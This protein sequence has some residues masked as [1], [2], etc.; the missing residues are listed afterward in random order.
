MKLLS[1]ISHTLTEKQIEE[2][3]NRLKVSS[4]VL[5]PEEIKVIWSNI[6]PYGDLP[7]DD[8]NKI[9]RWIDNESN[10]GDYVLVQGDFGAT[11]YV[12]DYC[13]NNDR[14]PIYSTTKREV[15]EYIEDGLVKTKRVFRHINFRKY[16][17]HD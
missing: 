8:I 13:I 14:I 5:M 9:I 12:V 7:I 11:Y 6:S 2:A 4:I 1:L 17:P 10:E 3:K 16:I 15:E